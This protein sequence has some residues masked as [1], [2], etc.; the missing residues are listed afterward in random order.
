[1][2]SERLD[3]FDW[4]DGT[5]RWRRD[6][7]GPP[8]VLCHGTPWSSQVWAGVARALAARWTVY[9]WD[10]LG[11]GTSD[12]H[13]GQDVSLVAQGELLA[14]LL[15]H[16]SLPRPAV[17]AHDVGGAVALRAHLVHGQPFSSL[18]LVDVVAL[19]PWGS[20][21]FQLV[22]NH[23]AVFEQ[24]PSALHAALVRAYIAGAS[25]RGLADADLD[26]LA[27]PWLD[28]AGQ[29]AFYRQIAQADQR[30]TDEIEPL[31]SQIG[32]PTLI[33]WGTADDWI[34]VDRAQ[35]LHHLIPGSRIEL[36]D[37]AGHLV[38]EDRPTELC[39]MLHRWLI[40]RPG[41]QIEAAR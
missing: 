3:E 8:V 17:V 37:D 30:Y 34:P 26:R 13:D 15:G 7:Q 36:I 12:M 39:L 10:M 5:V 27:A 21:F 6:G 31:Y 33:V 40:E 29:P 41:E 4:R 16:W 32:V 24:L 28:A 18:A 9:R 20:Q 23:H 14:A 19:A 35:Q 25:H 11:Y 38:Q 2:K 22:R 1:V